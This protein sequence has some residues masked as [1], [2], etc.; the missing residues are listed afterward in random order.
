MTQRRQRTLQEPP[1]T[2]QPEQLQQECLLV[3]H[4]SNGA[5]LLVERIQHER[6]SQVT[7]ATGPHAVFTLVTAARAAMMALAWAARLQQQRASAHCAPARARKLSPLS[8]P[9]RC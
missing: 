9:K 1:K 6:G 5:I 2:Q 8:C 4:A 7:Q 3:Q